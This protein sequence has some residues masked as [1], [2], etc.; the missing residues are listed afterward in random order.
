M[1]YVQTYLII[2]LLI[3]LSVNLINGTMPKLGELLFFALLWPA[4]LYVALK[5]KD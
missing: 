4:F 1:D 5:D 2:G 3:W